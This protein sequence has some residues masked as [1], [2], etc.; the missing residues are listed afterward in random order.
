MGLTQI[1]LADLVGIAPN[2]IA[3]I[4]A[5]R[6]FPSDTMLEKIASALKLE[7]FELFSIEPIQ[8]QWQADLLGEISCLI[9][10]KLQE[11]RGEIPVR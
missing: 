1:N 3:M 2:Y 11:A 4:E 5:G 7:S 10:V 6:R 9:S 8:N